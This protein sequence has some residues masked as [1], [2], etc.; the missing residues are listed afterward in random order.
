MLYM[1]ESNSCGNDYGFEVADGCLKKTKQNY[2]KLLNEREK[3]GKK[4]I[5][6]LR[7]KFIK[8]YNFSNWML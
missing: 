5:Y 1:N 8:E 6:Y 3:N 7:S 2:W 4:I